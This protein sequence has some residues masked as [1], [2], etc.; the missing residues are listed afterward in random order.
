M[1]CGGLAAAFTVEPHRTVSG[2]EQALSYKVLAATVC[3]DAAIIFYSHGEIGP[4]SGGYR[5]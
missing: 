1:E 5:S 2:L 3:A 4:R